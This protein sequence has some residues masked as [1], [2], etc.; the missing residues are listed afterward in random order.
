MAEINTHDIPSAVRYC[1]YCK[2]L[3][4][5][6]TSVFYH[7]KPN[8]NPKMFIH[9]FDLALTCIICGTD[10]YKAG[11]HLEETTHAQV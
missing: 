11:F 2:Q 7:S 5:H 9:T 8:K 4:R 6:Y 1:T 3:T 10:A